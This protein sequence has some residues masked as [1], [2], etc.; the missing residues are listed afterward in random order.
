MVFPY[1]ILESALL[2][3]VFIFSCKCKGKEAI[4]NLFVW[5]NSFITEKIPSKLLS[6]T[7]KPLIIFGHHNAPLNQIADVHIPVATPGLDCDGTLFRVDSAVVLPLK[8][9]RDNNLPTLSEVVRQIE[10]LL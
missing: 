2:Q 5:V 8:K 1:F 7:D 4:L 6:S 3:D 10:A 9:M